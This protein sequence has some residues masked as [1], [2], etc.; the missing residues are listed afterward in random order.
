M[1]GN[2]VT[3]SKRGLIIRSPFHLYRAALKIHLMDHL[4]QK[5]NQAFLIPAHHQYVI[6]TG[7]QYFF[8]GAEGLPLGIYN[9]QAD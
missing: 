9:F 8:N 5:R 4:A 2:K 6:R 1:G 7:R 3:T